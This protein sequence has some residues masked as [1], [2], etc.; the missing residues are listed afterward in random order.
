MWLLCSSCDLKRS[1][2]VLHCLGRSVYNAVIADSWRVFRTS[3]SNSSPTE[4]CSGVGLV[5]ESSPWAIRE[6]NKPES[7]P[8]AGGIE[9]FDGRG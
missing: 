8:P 3:G 4:S 1:P 9:V 2:H 7:A 6:L 5:S